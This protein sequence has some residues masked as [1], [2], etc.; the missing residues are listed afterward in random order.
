M[1]PDSLSLARFGPQAPAMDAMY[2]RQVGPE[3]CRRA[4]RAQMKADMHMARMPA[5]SWVCMGRL[6]VTV[7]WEAV[8]NLPPACIV[9]H[10]LRAEQLCVILSWHMHLCATQGVPP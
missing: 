3:A 6:H 7:V 8:G 1:H 4:C 9:R 10:R 2:D 5:I